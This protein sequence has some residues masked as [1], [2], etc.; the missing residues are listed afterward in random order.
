MINK[1][2]IFKNAYN[3][4]KY[5]GNDFSIWDR[6][7]DRSD[8]YCTQTTQMKEGFQAFIDNYSCKDGKK[9]KQVKRVS[10]FI[11][12]ITNPYC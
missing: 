4:E 6:D 1:N 3:A 11:Q 7:H 9:A 2:F 5:Q 12:K 8:D 10:K